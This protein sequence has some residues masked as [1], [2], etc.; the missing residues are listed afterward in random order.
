MQFRRLIS[1]LFY[2][3]LLVG[4]MHFYQTN[5][6][7]QTRVNIGI[8]AVKDYINRFQASFDDPS[9]TKTTKQTTK[10][11]T[12]TDSDTNGRW[13]SAKA[14]IYLD[15]Q[16]Q[17]LDSAMREAINAWNATGAF[18]F[19]IVNN[20]KSANLIATTMQ[21][22]QDQA[23][24]LTDMSVNTATGYFTDGHVYLNTAYLLNPEYGYTHERIVNT[25]EHEFGHAIGLSHTNQISVMQPAGSNYGIQQLDI[26]AV[27]Q[28]YAKA[29]TTS[30]KQTTVN[31]N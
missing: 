15:F 6:N 8:A 22:N 20:K 26:T 24:G 18:T 29:P 2:L 19:Q 17:S 27:Q 28:L 14:T 5:S 31:D 23:A 21:N 3:I 13:T 30:T 10:A 9:T 1:L 25:A 7:F 16:N 4:G 11:T 12:K